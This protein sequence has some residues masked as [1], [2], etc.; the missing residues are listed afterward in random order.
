MTFSWM[1]NLAMGCLG[2]TALACLSCSGSSNSGLG[3]NGGGSGSGSSPTV[4]VYNN[5]VQAVWNG[6]KVTPRA[7]ACNDVSATASAGPADTLE[8]GS[9]M[10]LLVTAQGAPNN[11]CTTSMVVFGLPAGPVSGPLSYLGFN[12]SGYSNGSVSFDC[13]ILNALVDHITL[14]G[15]SHAS[16][17]TFSTVGGVGIWAHYAVPAQW[18]F[19]SELSDLPYALQIN[20]DIIAS[21]SPFAVQNGYTDGIQVAAINNVVW[22]P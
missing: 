21:P 7:L 15:Y 20:F 16:Q 22:A 10:S 18:L 12:A 1:R 13:V 3:S 5:G 11:G 14:P 9:T 8:A 17:L 6:I 4:V 19:G 2:L